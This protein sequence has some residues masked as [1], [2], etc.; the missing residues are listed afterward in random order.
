M[1]QLLKLLYWHCAIRPSEQLCSGQCYLD[2]TSG[3]AILFSHL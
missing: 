3:V 1:R 2:L